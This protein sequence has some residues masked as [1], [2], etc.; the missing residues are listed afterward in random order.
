MSKGLA[1]LRLDTPLTLQNRWTT[2]LNC[3]E[4]NWRRCGTPHLSTELVR[5]ATMETHNC[6]IKSIYSYF[7]HIIFI[8]FCIPF[9]QWQ[10]NAHLPFAWS[11][12]A[13]WR[14]SE[15]K[16]ALRAGKSR[17]HHVQ[18]WSV[19][20]TNKVH[21]R[22][23][24]DWRKAL[25]LASFRSCNWVYILQS[26]VYIVQASCIEQT[27]VFLKNKSPKKVGV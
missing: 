19:Q 17:L 13:V 2:S 25:H 1:Q 9:C 11:N 10:S 14:S 24:I 4:G 8:Y 16:T 26:M 5:S 12:S 6:S 7:L 21:I 23:V 18:S 3:Q 22:V 20:Y 15:G 27:Y